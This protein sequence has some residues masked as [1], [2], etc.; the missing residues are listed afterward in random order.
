MVR[1]HTKDQ[2]QCQTTHGRRD[3]E[4]LCKSK[5]TDLP[6]GAGLTSWVHEDPAI[7][8]CPVEVRHHGAHITGTKG[9][10]TILQ[11]QQAKLVGMAMSTGQ[12]RNSNEAANLGRNEHNSWAGHHPCDHDNDAIK[13]H[14]NLV[15]LYP[16]QT[17]IHS[18]SPMKSPV[19]IIT[20][21]LYL[22]LT[23]QSQ[24]RHL[25]AI[26]WEI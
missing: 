19:I 20:I 6:V 17:N 9:G 25:L 8:K 18:Y 16:M 7:H 13:C 26:P 11:F 21:K 5:G 4:R 12:K 1:G 2:S 14:T 24:T 15:C 3:K 23:R 22:V 10:F